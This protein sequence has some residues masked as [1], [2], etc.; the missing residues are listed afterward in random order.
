MSPEIEIQTTPFQL[1]PALLGGFIVLFGLNSLLIK[2]RLFLSDSLF[3]TIYG[4]IIGPYVLNWMNPNDW[5]TLDTLSLQLSR[6]I[7]AIQVMAAG[8]TLPKKYLMIEWKS[9]LLLLI[10]VMSVMWIVCG[11]IIKLCF[12]I[13]LSKVDLRNIL[14]CESG[15]NDGLGYPFLFFAIYLM[16]YDNAGEAIW[17]W[18]YAT[19]G[20]QILLSIAIG[21]AVGYVSR[22]I[23]RIAQER[24]LI[25]KVSFL[26][27]AVALSVLLVG[28][29]TILGTDDILACFI[30]GNSFTWDDWF[31]IETNDA[32]FQEAIDGLFNVS[33][34]IY[35]GTIIP[36]KE[37]NNPEY[38]ITPTRLGL[39]GMFV[40]LFRRL[41]VVLAGYKL[42]PAIR[43]YKEA[44]FAGWFGPI[45][46]SAFFYAIVA[47][48]TLTEHGPQ[49]IW[50]LRL[51]YPI[52]VFIM[53]MS[54]IV[55]GITIPFFFLGRHVTSKTRNFSQQVF[56]RAMSRTYV[57]KDA[58]INV[59]QSEDDG[60]I[61]YI[62]PKDSGRDNTE[63]SI[64][65]TSGHA[66]T[67][68]PSQPPTMESKNVIFEG[69]G[70][71]NR[72]T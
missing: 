5:T 35:F 31:R 59:G 42:I 44:L 30:A 19:W 9:I 38:H 24:D 63:T 4:I 47:K 62:V 58:G 33:F 45:G 43:N 34:F 22:K 1:V 66:C 61:L 23:L 10:P 39:C 20:Y 15:A 12:N 7:L 29:C 6:Y 69:N 57:D 49:D 40:M 32:H 50:D 21:A 36:W 25:D 26:S 11:G 72:A 70:R 37:F 64:P 71:Q 67:P 27:F 52:V 14:S 28:V 55:H 48:Q 18:L 68:P 17:T 2:E 60:N 13:T 8:I 46:V 51:V 41:P 53:L 56:E 16:R 54:V 3:A 65:E